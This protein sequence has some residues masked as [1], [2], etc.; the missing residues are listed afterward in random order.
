MSDKEKV[1]K[2]NALL[3]KNNG[4]LNYNSLKSLK[5]KDKVTNV[6]GGN[7][8]GVI[9]NQSQYANV[10]KWNPPPAKMSVNMTHT[11]PGYSKA[12]I[13]AKKDESNI[14]KSSTT[15][16]IGPTGP[17]VPIQLIRDNI[18]GYT[19]DEAENG[20]E[21]ADK[22]LP[23]TL[24]GGYTIMNNRIR[25]PTIYSK[26][27]IRDDLLPL[28]YRAAYL[29]NS[30][31]ENNRS[32]EVQTPDQL[33][34]KR[35]QVLENFL[36]LLKRIG[37]DDLKDAIG[38]LA[39]IVT[40]NEYAA[41][42]IVPKV[43]NN[44]PNNVVSIPNDMDAMQALIAGLNNTSKKA[45]ILDEIYINA[46]LTMFLNDYNR[47]SVRPTYF[48]LRPFDQMR[49]F[50]DSEGMFSNQMNVYKIRALVG[51]YD[52]S[53]T[54]FVY[55]D[56]TLMKDYTFHI[57]SQLAIAIQAGFHGDESSSCQ[58][59]VRTNVNL[60][61]NEQEFYR[62]MG[63]TIFN[64]I[65]ADEIATDGLNLETAY[66]II[67]GKQQ[68]NEVVNEHLAV[69]NVGLRQIHNETGEIGNRIREINENLTAMEEQKLRTAR[70]QREA[71]I[72][73]VE[74]SITVLNKNIIA[75]RNAATGARLRH[76][77]AESKQY[78]QEEKM[79][80]VIKLAK[81]IELGKLR[82]EDTTELELELRKN[83]DAKTKALIKAEQEEIAALVKRERERERLE[84]S[85]TSPK[86]ESSTRSDITHISSSTQ[87][88]MSTPVKPREASSDILSNY[89]TI[90]KEEIDA[91]I[92][93]PLIFTNDSTLNVIDN[94]KMIKEMLDGDSNYKLD[95]LD[96]RLTYTGRQFDIEAF[97][98]RSV[99]MIEEMKSFV[100][101]NRQAIE[102]C[103]KVIG[104]INQWYKNYLR[105]KSSSSSSPQ[106]VT[107]EEQAS[108]LRT[109]SPRAPSQ[110]TRSKGE[111][112]VQGQ[113]IASFK[114]I[115]GGS[116]TSFI[117]RM[118][119]RMNIKNIVKY[120]KSA[121]VINI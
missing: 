19:P 105:E 117:E 10:A 110:N 104:I 84:E 78:E 15:K 11:E 90:L 17:S 45:L 4:K 80:E 55:V 68:N 75:A 21:A 37:N 51:E 13:L 67:T 88:A 50:T 39:D 49:S 118:H 25:E 86:P 34:E 106:R 99:R 76:Q 42:N 62:N 102:I 58:I 113:G 64:E 26:V 109:T 79:L 28:G 35:K 73:R 89:R 107:V 47:K 52:F 61:S 115:H 7:I 24:N 108:R 121:Y 40:L 53:G 36:V 14:K 29:I 43:V 22:G 83:E 32:P 9:K 41:N 96:L 85:L 46:M 48:L 3:K 20:L 2:L 54:D 95:G 60:G 38:E 112:R 93:T 30:L 57:I 69:N 8:S 74:S 103:D 94:I 111:K 116:I 72:R 12:Q 66:S 59:V 97:Q 91:A 101:K 65:F 5:V 71:E 70:N 114:H 56:T 92:P 77:Y 44:L 81:L 33:K 119:E 16:L 63:K 18:K 98:R 6:K 1:I 100:K 27:G 120:N 31:K 87:G 82:E 23:T